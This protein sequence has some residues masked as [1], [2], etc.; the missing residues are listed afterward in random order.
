MG[1]GEA[2]E[3]IACFDVLVPLWCEDCELAE[4]VVPEREGW[5]GD[6]GPEGGALFGAD[7]GAAFEARRAVEDVEG[8]FDGD[9][10]DGDVCEV[11]PGEVEHV[12]VEVHAF[13]RAELGC[14]L[15]GVEGS[16]GAGG[17]VCAEAEFGE[18]RE[19]ATDGGEGAVSGGREEEVH[20]PPVV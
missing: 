15:E 8:V 13:E 3:E 4:V 17:I 19:V 10:H 11:R 6:D 18:E 1:G 20:G 2:P 9:G 5:G 16:V 7:E 12:R 14:E